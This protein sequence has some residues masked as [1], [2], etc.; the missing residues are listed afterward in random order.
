MEQVPTAMVVTAEPETVHSMGESE[1]ND[2]TRGSSA[3]VEADTVTGWPRI[4]S[5]GWAK[6]IACCL[7]PVYAWNERCTDWA[8]S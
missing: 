2:T 3:S 7:V 5:G 6:V 1:R 4:A 8:A